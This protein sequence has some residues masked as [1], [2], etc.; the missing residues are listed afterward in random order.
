MFCTQISLAR[1]EGLGAGVNLLLRFPLSRVSRA[2]GAH[3]S[4][5]WGGFSLCQALVPSGSRAVNALLLR[6]VLRAHAGSLGVLQAGGPGPQH[7]PLRT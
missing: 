3:S 1:A 7:A 2:P 4:F 5:S 6:A